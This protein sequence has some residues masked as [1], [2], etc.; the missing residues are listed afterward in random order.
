M[1]NKPLILAV[2]GPTAAGKT[3][4]A[5]QLT[6]HFPIELINM[7]SAQVYRDMNIGT[8][9]I[10]EA[11]QCQ[12]PHH[13]MNIITP[14]QN[15]SAAQFVDDVT[16]LVPQINERGNIPLLVGGTPLYYKALMDGLADLPS[17]NYSLRDELR[18][19][20]A[21]HGHAALHTELAQADP[22]LA[23][24]IQGK[25]TQRLV[26]FIEILRLTGRPPSELFAEQKNTSKKPRFR[27]FHLCFF[28]VNRAWLHQRIERR[29]DSMLNHDFIGEVKMLREKYMLTLDHPSM[30]CAGY[31]QVWEY[32]DGAYNN[33]PVNKTNKHT[34]TP[35]QEMCDRGVFA[36]RQLAKRQLTWL[37]K[38]PAD[39]LIENAEC[40]DF[41]TIVNDIRRSINGAFDE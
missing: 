38:I 25:D 31:R 16:E 4:L 33:L 8:A 40:I 5:L 32:L 20:I 23:A 27:F 41:E 22:I 28:P 30:R 9:K 24:Q 7:D 12:Y 29:F 18:N 39:V 14:E 17:A 13:L 34:N 15:Y 3:D 1:P 6:R 10:S 19:T 37:R 36:T 11:E 26:R 2:T 35:Y 21:E